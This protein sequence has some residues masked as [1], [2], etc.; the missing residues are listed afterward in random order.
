MKN[1]IVELA[2]FQPYAYP[3]SKSELNLSVEEIDNVLK[4]IGLNNEVSRRKKGYELDI[5]SYLVAA[6]AKDYEDLKKRILEEL[7]DKKYVS[8]ILIK[9]GL[10]KNI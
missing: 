8:E 9:K 7:K 2:I 4:D 6:K 5:I 1:K 10:S 3:W